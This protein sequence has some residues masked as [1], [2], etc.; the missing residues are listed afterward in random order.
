MTN[1][2]SISRIEVAPR[3]VA[4]GIVAKEAAEEAL[5]RVR[6]WA[7][8]PL[9][10]GELAEVLVEFGVAV[11][12]Y[13]DEVDDLEESYRVTLEEAAACSG[14]LVVVS[15][16]ELIRGEGGRDRLEFVRDGER[17]GRPAE[18]GAG[19][20]LSRPAVFACLGR[21]APGGEDER[22]FHRVLPGA[23]TAADGE[24]YVLVTPA[25]AAALGEEFGLA[26]DGRGA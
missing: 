2:R 9:E 5:G 12:V 8:A 19:R 11:A 13:A 20:Y 18:R 21:L 6:D 22:T 4:L 14:G 7:D 16:V 1:K 24:V 26:L 25:Q 17:I 3:L 10:D 15:D 23:G